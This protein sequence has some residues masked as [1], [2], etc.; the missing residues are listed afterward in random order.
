MFL[1]LAWMSLSPWG[2]AM[3]RWLD[4]AG[5]TAAV[6]LLAVTDSGGYSELW[7]GFGF[8]ESLAGMFVV[9][10]I[11]VSR[12]GRQI[13]VRVRNAL[14]FVGV[15]IIS[16]GYVPLMIQ[17]G[18]ALL[19]LGDTTY[20]VLEE[21]IGPS[22][23][24]LPL[25]NFT[26]Q[27]TS[28]LGYLQYLV[29]LL[30]IEIDNL[31]LAVAIANFLNF[32]VV[33]LI[34]AIVRSAKLLSSWTI[35]LILFVPLWLQVGTYGG[36]SAQVAEFANAA[37]IVP[38]LLA[39]WITIVAQKKTRANRRGSRWTWLLV[40][41]ALT[42]SLMNNADIGLGAF[43]AGWALLVSNSWNFGIRASG[44]IEAAIGCALMVCMVLGV[45]ILFGAEP[46]DMLSMWIGIRASSSSLYGLSI[47]PPLFGPWVLVLSMVVYTFSREV[48]VVLRHRNVLQR[49]S[50][51]MTDLKERLSRD[52]AVLF[53]VWCLFFLFKF[54]HK[55]IN[56]NFS[57]LFVP[58]FLLGMSLVRPMLRTR[59]GDLDFRRIVHQLPNWALMSV[60]V[61]ALFH[62]PDPRDEW[63]R[64]LSPQGVTSEWSRVPGRPNDVFSIDDSPIPNDVVLAVGSLNKRLK[65]DGYSVGYFGYLGNTMETLSGVDNVFA[66]TAVE[67]LR[68]N[69]Q[70]KH[71]CRRLSASRTEYVIV[72]LAPFVC[73]GYSKVASIA[74]Y[75]GRSLDLVRL[76]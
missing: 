33:A 34:I 30:N 75:D 24:S 73:E 17:P 21:L 1:V 57:Q 60:L 71:A 28:L 54:L 27:Y 61:A 56:P 62:A 38:G 67:S 47:S 40:G 14:Q 45:G 64:L 9:A 12:F 59:V 53:A 49:R 11:S 52:V 43:V 5:A 66:M 29:T 39:L 13:S 48:I 65:S 63:K 37:R 32:A 50:A 51:R 35:T 55:P 68:F 19:N 36:S 23:G 72:W 2:S 3:T 42:I 46:L 6:L 20:H 26:P 16:I 76:F 44:V 18:Y 7:A 22:V 10:L 31:A 4:L 70:E 69:D 15:T 58:A 8:R 25:F 41:V 74:L